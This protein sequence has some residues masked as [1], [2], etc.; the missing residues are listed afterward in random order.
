MEDEELTSIRAEGYR[1]K[2][3]EREEKLSKHQKG[4]VPESIPDE[5]PLETS[6]ED[7]ELEQESENP[8]TPEIEAESVTEAVSEAVEEVVEE[9]AEEP[10]EPEPEP[11]EATESENAT[12]T[13]EEQLLVIQ[14]QIRERDADE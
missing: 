1:S 5:V 4:E 3:A 8:V 6:T 12:L 9:I 14:K 11:S 10:A 2:E 7:N 13:L